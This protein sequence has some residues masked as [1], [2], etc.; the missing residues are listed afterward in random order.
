MRSTLI[1][2]DAGFLGPYTR[3]LQSGQ[4]QQ[5]VFGATDAGPFWMSPEDRILNRLDR[6]DGN[7]KVNQRNKAE[8]IVDLQ[9]K[10]ISTKGKNKQE[11]VALC[12]SNKY[13]HPRGC[14]NQRRLDWKAKGI[15]S[16][17]VG[18]RFH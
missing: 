18:E 16:S 4:T 1:E 10:G 13:H 12:N 17:L 5:L 7:P 6:N 15:T 11:L 14:K 9:G 3:Q 8:L 2:K